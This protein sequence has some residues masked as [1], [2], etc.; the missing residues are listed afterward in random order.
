[1]TMKFENIEAVILDKDGV[2]VDFNKAWLRI[3]AYPAQLTAER[4]SNTSEELIA[5]RNACI[6]AVGVDDDLDIVDPYGPCSMP[7]DTVRLALATGL[8]LTKNSTDPNFGWMHS[9]EI[10][11][12]CMQ[13]AKEEM[14]VSE[15]SEEVPGSIAKIK[16]I[17]ENY[18]VAIYTSDSM[19]NTIETLDKFDLAGCVC[20]DMQTGEKKDADNYLSLCEKIGVKAENTLLISDG[21][22]DIRAAKACGGKTIAVLSGVL[23]EDYNLNTIRDLTDEILPSIA[24]LDLSNI[25]GPKKKQAA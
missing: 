16:E 25:D 13:Q 10:I 15:L 22:L 24:E 14:K 19:Q 21:P 20:E 17:A 23:D 7:K 8:Y 12:E 5:I 18:K 4:A 6:K 3:I 1:M 11:D 9:F 2:F